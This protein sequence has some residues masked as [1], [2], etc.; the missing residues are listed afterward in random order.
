MRLWIRRWRPAV[1][2]MVIIFIASATPASDL[3]DLGGLDFFAKKGAHM[4][5]YA[6]LAAAYFHALNHE[7]RITRLRLAIAVSLVILYAAT[8]EW[9]QRF[10]PGRTPKFTDVC[11]DTAGGLIGLAV[12]YRM[13]KLRAREA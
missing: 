3:P 11:I 9:H 10:T 5:G 4:L 7:K 8:D 13:K 1:I 2:V 12:T 6:L